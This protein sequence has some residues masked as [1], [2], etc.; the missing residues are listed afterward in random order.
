M[1]T[2]ESFEWQPTPHFVSVT[3]P[4][5]ETNYSF[6]WRILRC[7]YISKQNGT[8]MTHW[9]FEQILDNQSTNKS[10]QRSQTSTKADHYPHIAWIPDLENQH[11]D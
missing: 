8:L 4:D 2:H 7:T 6:E 10:T 11:G 3:S 9:T 5:E 1:T